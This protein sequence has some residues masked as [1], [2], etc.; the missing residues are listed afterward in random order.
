VFDLN[1]PDN[2]VPRLFEVSALDSLLR[3]PGAPCSLG[4]VKSQLV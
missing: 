3:E 2:F 4:R 1:N